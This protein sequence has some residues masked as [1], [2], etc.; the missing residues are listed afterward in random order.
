VVADG[1]LFKILAKICK[2]FTHLKDII[3][4]EAAPDDQVAT[5]KAAGLTI[6]T[7]GEVTAAGKEAATAPTPPHTHDPPVNK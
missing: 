6:H 1:R 7:M 5:L 4:L 2:Q 3:A